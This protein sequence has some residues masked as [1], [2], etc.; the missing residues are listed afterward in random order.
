MQVLA[1]SVSVSSYEFCLVDL[2][3]LVSLVSSITSGSYTLTDSSSSGFPQLWREG[4]DEDIPFRVVT[5]HLECSKI[6]LCLSSHN[7]CGSLYLFPSSTGG[8]FSDDSW[9]RHW[10]ISSAEYHHESF[11]SFIWLFNTSSIWLYLRSLGYLVSGSWLL[12]PCW[13][14]L[15]SHGVGHKTNQI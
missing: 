11:L 1:A 8:C 2:E 9:I 6:C 14:W 4:F 10:P 5:F 15:P 3:S 13:I 7:V 12:E